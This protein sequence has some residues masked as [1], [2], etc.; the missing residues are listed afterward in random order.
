[1]AIEQEKL[2]WENEVYHLLIKR[3]PERKESFATSSGIEIPPI[4]LPPE[5]QDYMEDLGFLASIRIR[6]VQLTMYRGRYWT[7]RQYADMP[8]PRNR[9]NVTAICWT[10]GRPPVCGFRPADTNWL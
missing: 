4:L 7:M 5:K 1:M 2:R 8:P 10:R 9:I 3:F 6:G